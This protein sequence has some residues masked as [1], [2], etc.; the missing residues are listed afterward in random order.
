MK[1]PIL[2]I[3]LAVLIIPRAAL[4]GW[5]PSGCASGSCMPPT[6]GPVGPPTTETEVYRPIPADAVPA[7]N[8][9]GNYLW[10]LNRYAPS[11][12]W[13]LQ[14][15]SGKVIGAYVPSQNTYQK[16]IKAIG[17]NWTWSEPCNPPVP[18]CDAMKKS[19]PPKDDKAK[20]PF[21]KD[22]QQAPPIQNFGIDVAHLGKGP[23][24][25]RGGKEITAAE[26]IDAA[27]GQIPEDAQK[28]HLTMFGTTEECKPVLDTIPEDVKQSWVIKDYR[29]DH[30]LAACG[31]STKGHPT[32]YAQTC[33]GKV[34]FRQDTYNP[35]IWA[36]VRQ[37][38]PNYH[39]DKDP[40]G[41][42]NAAI[43][44]NTN[45][46]LLLCGAGLILFLVTRK[47]EN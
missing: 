20:D 33:D 36:M 19:W 3:I 4:G 2:A 18:L 46:V 23:A 11:E 13:T 38:D 28:P 24:Y 22:N 16:L 37:A 30:P 40:N 39:P 15:K 21:S 26:A 41:P 42:S 34:L 43:G 44:I 9:D 12:Q 5:G 1:L 6:D 32:I 7:P 25:T 14:D 45:T 47:K 35:A 10:S 17:D 29:P 31:F 27:G 8:N